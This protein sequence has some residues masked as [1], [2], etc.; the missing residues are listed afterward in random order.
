MDYDLQRLGHRE[1]EHLSQALVL[2]VLGAR[3]S[4]FGDGPDGGR[5]ASYLGK[6]T[7]CGS[8]G[9]TEVWDGYTVLQAKFRQRPIA[10]ANGQADVYVFA[11]LAHA[12]K[13]TI[14]PLDLDQWTFYVM[15]TARL[16]AAVGPQK[17][18]SLSALLRLEPAK[19]AY[20]DLPDLVRRA[21]EAVG[22]G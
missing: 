16:N 15:P 19:G 4:V 5:E 12:D 10:T 1:F 14:D 11:L 2:K 13:A 17:T 21:A 9:Q 8:D 20:S 7:W 3:T 22:A 18:I 6:S